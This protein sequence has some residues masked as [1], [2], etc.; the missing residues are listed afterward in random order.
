MKQPITI[1]IPKC[2]KCK[3]G[4]DPQFTTE[5]DNDAEGVPEILMIYGVCEDCKMITMSE[6]VKIKDIPGGEDVF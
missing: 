2:E 3:N 1:Q 4:L 6:I 5:Q